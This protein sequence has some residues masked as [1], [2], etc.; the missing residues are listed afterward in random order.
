[1][2]ENP[3][4]WLYFPVLGDLLSAD[5][6]SVVTTRAK[7]ATWGQVRHVREFAGYAPNAKPLLPYLPDDLH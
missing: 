2:T 6:L 7:R 1:M 5:V 4:A 3:M